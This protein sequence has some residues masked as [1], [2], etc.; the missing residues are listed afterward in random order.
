MLTLKVEEIKKEAAILIRFIHS[1]SP[2]VPITVINIKI[3]GKEI[4][5]KSDQEEVY[6]TRVQETIPN[7]LAVL[8]VA[9]IR[10]G[11]DLIFAF[12]FSC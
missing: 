2:S 5:D 11:H 4:T 9:S 8:R 7:I 12:A 1:C 3:T 6:S 10:G